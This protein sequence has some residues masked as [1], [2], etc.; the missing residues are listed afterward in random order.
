MTHGDLLSL[1]DRARIRIYLG[2]LLGVPPVKQIFDIPGDLNKLFDPYHCY[3]D[4][5]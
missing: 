1:T 4:S 2:E 3:F 5:L